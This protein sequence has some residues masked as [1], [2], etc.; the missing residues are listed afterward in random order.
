MNQGRRIAAHRTVPEGRIF[1]SDF[2][3][4]RKIAADGLIGQYDGVAEKPERRRMRAQ[5]R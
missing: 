2:R 1:R 5:S 4:G 3:H